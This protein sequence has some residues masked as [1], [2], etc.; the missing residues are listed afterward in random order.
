MRDNKVIIYL[1]FLLFLLLLSNPL[2]PVLLNAKSH[3]AV[4]RDNKKWTFMVYL[5]ADN[6]LESYGHSDLNEM[7]AV[8]SDSNINIVVLWDGRGNGDGALYYVNAGSVDTFPVSDAGIADEPAMSDP[9]TLDSFLQW[10]I[11]NYPADHYALSIWDHGSGIFRR[12]DEAELM[13]GVCND[14]HG[15]G[16]EIELWELNDVLANAV[17][18]AGKKIDIVGFDVCL[19]GHVETHYQMIPYVDYGIASEANEPG[20]GWD[21]ET[22]LEA[23][24][25]DPDM[26]PSTFASEIVTAFLD[27]Y[28]SHVTQA[29]VD[30]SQLN[31]SFMPKL[32]DFAEKL[33]N[34]MYHYETPI[35]DAKSDAQT[36][37]HSNARDLYDFAKGIQQ[38]GSLPAPLRNSASALMNEFGNTVV[39]EGQKSFSGAKGMMIYFPNNGPSSTYTSK[40]DMASSKWDEFLVEYNDPQ[41]HYEM[42]LDVFDEDGDEHEDD[43][44]ITVKDF[45]GGVGDNSEI[46]IDGAL[47]GTTDE[48]G[49]LYHYD[50]GKGIHTVQGTK[51][52]FEMS[53]QFTIANRP[54]VAIALLPDP[55]M[56]GEAVRFNSSLSSDADGDLLSY[57]WNFGDGG[58]S[59]QADP[60]HVYE[61]D[62]VFP[63]SLIVIDTDS[64]ESTPFTFDMAIENL[65]PVAEAGED[66]EAVEDETITFDSSMSF[67]TPADRAALL[68]QWDFGDDT[69]FDW[70]NSTFINHS[71]SNSNPAGISKTYSVKLTVKD[72]DGIISTDTLNVTVSNVPPTANAGEEIAA[73]EDE[74][75]TLSGANSTDTAS[76]IDNLTYLWDL[77]GDSIF[78]SEGVD[79]NVSVQN[80]KI[81]T[82]SFSEKGTYIATLRVIDDN[83]EYSDANVKIRVMNVQPSAVM[84][85]D[86]LS[87]SEDEVIFLNGSLSTDSTSDMDSLY[88][89]WEVENGIKLDGME[90]NISFPDPGIYNITLMVTDDD[91]DSDTTTLSF[92]VENVPP[93]AHL[94]D[95]GEVKEGEV[96]VFNA[97]GSYDTPSDMGKL[98]YLWDL[99]H[100]GKDFSEDITNN[101]YMV[102]HT[103]TTSGE[104]KVMV[105]VVDDNGAFDTMTITFSVL[106]VKPEAIV[107]VTSNT[108]VTGDMLL[109]DGRLSNDSVNDKEALKFTWFIDDLV[110][111]SGNRTFTHTFSKSGDY[112]VRLEVQDDDGAVDSMQIEIT[113]ND[114]PDNGISSMLISPSFANRGIFIYI[115]AA[116]LF[117]ILILFIV[118]GK[119]R[120]KRALQ[121]TNDGIRGEPETPQISEEEKKREYERL[122]GKGTPDKPNGKADKTTD[123][124]YV[125]E[126]D[127]PFMLEN[128]API[129]RKKGTPGTG[130]C[131]K[132][133]FSEEEISVSE[134]SLKDE[135]VPIRA[136]KKGR[137][138]KNEHSSRTKRLKALRAARKRSKGEKPSVASSKD[139][140]K[141]SELIQLLD[142]VAVES[143]LE[144]LVP[145]DE[146]EG[147][148]PEEKME[149]EWEEDDSDDESEPEGDI[150]QDLDLWKL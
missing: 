100:D 46:R 83:G 48:N 60:H 121:G 144:T 53:G 21:Y 111:A 142:E 70:T 31:S 39:E 50:S 145:A 20:D 17:A 146:E 7:K 12:S 108:I 19:L 68:Y 104:R 88:Y 32:D 23:L 82:H 36:C 30:L 42:T 79:E 98:I 107:N 49:E 41:L 81:I 47:V 84:P 43:V 1:S 27:F 92:H 128:D 22:P 76:D 90:A 74:I 10:A 11:T 96:L 55:V 62:G 18:A 51:S 119:R 135:P 138:K 113:V 85:Y 6:N 8:G 109:F 97:S 93:V 25:N 16:G 106:N 65:P 141:F 123:P 28:S 3:N 15:G 33:T 140:D 136:G 110:V 29:A 77:D 87:I 150:T 120:K 133:P 94:V 37:G 75:F 38:D 134:F 67:D 89:S 66:V 9:D 5:D 45:I 122:Y 69:V 40:I 118:I 61:D 58:G 115:G 64:A 99:D 59:A 139:N 86:N 126:D 125:A 132:D 52:G 14:E 114:P 148:L 102:M 13:K 91:G 124:T 44:L 54:P 56:A 71:Y 147:D 101:S 72:D 129:K 78:N 26:A 130:K 112:V 103:Y 149:L 63:V 35:K 131:N 116:L 73:S 143:E 117:F 105:K 4:G 34:Y 95:V 57:M 127:N 2:S 80:G 137:S 24:S